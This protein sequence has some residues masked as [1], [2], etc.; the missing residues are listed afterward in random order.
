M[1]LRS[2]PKKL[3]TSNKKY[4]NISISNKRKEVMYYD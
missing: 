3:L 4:V 2:P 1:K